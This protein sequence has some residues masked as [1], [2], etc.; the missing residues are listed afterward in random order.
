MEDGKKSQE[1]IKSNSEELL[2]GQIKEQ[3]KALKNIFIGLGIFVIGIVA[4]L[5]LISSADYFE[6]KGINF[7]VVKEIAPYQT[8][9][10]IIYNGEEVQ[11]NFFL[12]NDPRNLE[13]EIPFEGEFVL[14]EDLI[15]NMT[16]D[17]NCDGD[18]IIGV[19]NMVN[20]Y[21]LLG[22]KVIKDPE[23]GCD[24]LKGRYSFIQIREGKET[25]IEQFAPTCYNLYVNNCEVLKVTERF[26]VEIFSKVNE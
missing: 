1:E 25:S 12:R 2:G 11:Y 14:R 3:N 16:K 22:T 18:G 6:H 26:M 7:N 21:G 4:V 17:F 15:I 20:L 19:A 23:A 10:P 24:A 5:L 13:K 8:S 9:L